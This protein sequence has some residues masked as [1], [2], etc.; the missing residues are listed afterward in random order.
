ME[1]DHRSSLSFSAIML[2]EAGVC[3]ALAKILGSIKLFE[4][5]LGG[6]ITPASMAPLFLF[7]IRWGWKRGLLVGFAYG[8]VDMLIGGYVIHPAQMILDYPAAYAMCG[9]AGLALVKSNTNTITAHLPSILLATLMRALMHIIS[10]LIF[11]GEGRSFG[12]SLAH[13]VGYNLQFLL[14]DVVICIVV[15]YLLWPPLS[16]VFR[17]QRA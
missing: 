2:A 12:A 15:L 10:G 11:F 8:I 3:I 14:P 5:P 6:S 4:M 9:L 13:S 17:D 7:A 1:K 16:R